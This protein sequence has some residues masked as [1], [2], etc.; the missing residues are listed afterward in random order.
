TCNQLPVSVDYDLPIIVVVLNNY[1]LGMVRQW[2]ELFY[3]RRYI[4]VDLKGKA[5]IAKVSEG[6]GAK[7]FKVSRVS[8]LKEALQ[9][10][11]KQN[12]TTVIDVIVEREDNVFPM[13]PPAATLDQVITGR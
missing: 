1:L 4:A 7:A 3:G 8:E 13:I 5:D 6:L 11:V 2:Q 12:E 9:T 10:A